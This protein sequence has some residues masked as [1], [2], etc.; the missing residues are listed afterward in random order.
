MHKLGLHGGGI[1]GRSVREL[2]TWANVRREDGV[3]GE[4][5][6][7]RYA[8]FQ[9][10]G[11]AAPYE[12]VV[13]RDIRPCLVRALGLVRPPPGNIVV[14][15]NREG[16]ARCRAE[17]RWLRRVP[18]YPER[19]RNEGGQRTRRR[20]FALSMNSL[21]LSLMGVGDDRPDGNS[22]MNTQTMWRAD[23]QVVAPPVTERVP[24]PFVRCGTN[25]PTP[26]GA[27]VVSQRADSTQ[28]KTKELICVYLLR[29]IQLQSGLVKHLVCEGA[30]HVPQGF[31]RA[32]GA[33]LQEGAHL[34]RMC[35][36][37]DFR[38]PQAKGGAAPGKRNRCIALTEGNA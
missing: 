25:K 37:A 11:N 7:R 16:G 24:P 32:P 29:T 31:P 23:I 36:V 6:T 30:M 15:R 21:L 10:T 34:G 33:F 28:Q 19:D 14:H 20:S 9:V 1:H 13:D 17:L 2:H 26:L 27:P 38:F 12:R 18:A 22:A 8:R 35:A 4:C 3:A 5:P